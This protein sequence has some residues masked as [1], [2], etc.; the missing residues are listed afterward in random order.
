MLAPVILPPAPVTC[1]LVLAMTLGVVSCVAALTVA[2]D[3][4]A[5]IV[6]LPPAKL[7]V[8]V[9]RNAETLALP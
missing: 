7:P 9:G 3:P 2:K 8:Y 1:I 4:A 5:V 6:M